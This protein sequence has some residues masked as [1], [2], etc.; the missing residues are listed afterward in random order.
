MINR[1][2]IMSD[3]DTIDHITVLPRWNKPVDREY[4]I[5]TIKRCKT[6][7][8][9][10]FDWKQ[11]DSARL[12]AATEEQLLAELVSIRETLMSYVF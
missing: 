8:A 6:Y 12:S 9:D 10:V 1:Q 4:A 3:V 2:Q 7:Y 11:S 5:R